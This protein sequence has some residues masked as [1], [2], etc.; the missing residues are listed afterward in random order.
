[1]DEFKED[2]L[3]SG[4][5]GKGGEVKSPKQPIAIGL[6]EA[7]KAGAEVPKKKSKSKLYAGRK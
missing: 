5:G 4:P 3:K 7:R 2:K 1:M 6:S